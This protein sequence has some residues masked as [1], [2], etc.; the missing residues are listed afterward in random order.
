M[1][2]FLEVTSSDGKGFIN[3]D[4]VTSIFPI[5][6]IPTTEPV[7]IKE[8]KT[9]IGFNDNTEMNVKESITELTIQFRS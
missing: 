2:Q 4:N 1:R 5:S 8:Y 7:T 6:T 9:T 3:L